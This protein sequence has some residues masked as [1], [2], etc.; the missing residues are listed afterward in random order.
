MQFWLAGIGASDLHGYDWAGHVSL[1]ESLKWGFPAVID[2][3]GINGGGGN[4]VGSQSPAWGSSQYTEYMREP[5]S[6]SGHWILVFIRLGSLVEHGESTSADKL[7]GWSYQMILLSQGSQNL[8]TRYNYCQQVHIYTQ[9]RSCW[10]Y[11]MLF[12]SLNIMAQVFLM[13]LKL[14][15]YSTMMAII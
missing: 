7:L 8:P 15:E 4:S 3:D 12:F 11:T 10:M 6:V 14:F 5:L 1:I 13:F 2:S 9:L